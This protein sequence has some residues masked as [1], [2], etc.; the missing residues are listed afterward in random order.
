MNEYPEFFRFDY[1]AHFISFVVHIA[2]LFER[3]ATTVNI[4]NL[5]SDAGQ[6]SHNTDSLTIEAERLLAQV[7]SIIKKAVFLRSNLFAHRSAKLNYDE[8]F[9]RASVTPDELR[10]LNDASFQ[11]VGSLSE[12]IG[13]EM[14]VHNDIVVA[15]LNELIAQI[16]PI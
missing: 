9:K 11:I 3:K 2:A 7:K 8:V 4:P 1:H 15:H 14:P 5:V 13:E 6:H 16:T 10:S 12:V